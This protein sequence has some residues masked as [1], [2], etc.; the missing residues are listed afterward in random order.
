MSGGVAIKHGHTPRR[1]QDGQIVYLRPPSGHMRELRLRYCPEGTEDGKIIF[2]FHWEEWLEDWI[3][4]LQAPAQKHP[5]FLEW[6][7]DL[8]TDIALAPA[9]MMI[10]QQS[11]FL[12]VK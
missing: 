2:H 1:E 12:G 10:A 8:G 11:F 4:P 6:W 9:R 5:S 7:L 3:K